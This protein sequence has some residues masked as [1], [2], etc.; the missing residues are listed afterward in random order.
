MPEALSRDPRVGSPYCSDP[1]CVYCKELREFAAELR[2]RHD[3]A[4][5]KEAAHNRGGFP[6]TK[7]PPAGGCCSTKKGKPMSLRRSVVLHGMLRGQ[8]RERMCRITAVR[9]TLP[10]DPAI[11]EYADI[12][13]A[14]TDNFP[15]GD[16][17]VAVAG[18]T[19]RLKRE[20]G[21]YLSRA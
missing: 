19:I 9:V 4:L 5:R 18:R 13:V 20:D 16:Y 11:S 6:T 1:T 14:D 3:S 17:E 7:E 15:D 10:G 12:S 21:F 8:G 2:K